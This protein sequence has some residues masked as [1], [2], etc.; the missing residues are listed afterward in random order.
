MKKLRGITVLALFL[1]APGLLKGQ[2]VGLLRLEKDLPPENDA[3]LWGGVE[4]GRFKPTYEALFQW[5]AG[6]EA[7][8]VRYGIHTTWT[9]TLSLEQTTGDHPGAS[10][11]LEPGYFP[12]DLWDPTS[13]KTSRQTGRLDIGLLSNLS[14]LWEAGFRASV[15]AANESRQ[16]AF[17]HATFGVDALLEPTLA[18]VTDDDARIIASYL[19]R[20]RM[21]QVRLDLSGDGADASRPV[22]LDEGMRYG[23]FEPGLTLFPVMEFSHGFFGRYYSPELSGG[24]GIT[25]KRGRAGGP[26]YSRFT[27]PGSILKGCFEG[28]SEGFE[29]DQVFRLSYQ[30]DRDQLRETKEDGF[31]SL[32]DRVT[33]NAAFGYALRPHEGILK[34]VGI[35][36]DGHLWHHRGFVSTQDA[37]RMVGGLATLSASLV[38]GR[39]DLDVRASAGGGKWLDSGRSYGPNDESVRLAEDWARNMDY[40]MLPRVGAGGSVTYHAAFL[41]GLTLQFDTDWLRAFKMIHLGGK[42]RNVATLRI[43]YHF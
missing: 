8:M 21:E 19:V 31:A 6:A 42:N 41:E 14:D 27:F 9:G 23:M 32:S 30:R 20:L 13:R 35:D 3:V 18:F 22:F 24:F 16:V 26:D 10:L 34:R 17:H 43:G 29:V 38:L 5:S 40:R 12:M 4:G 39:V 11:F 33:R 7:R 15:K 25:W 37:A 28:M 2:D 36:L 1:L